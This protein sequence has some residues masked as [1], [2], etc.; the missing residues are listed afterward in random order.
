[1]ENNLEYSKQLIAWR[2]RRVRAMA[3]LEAGMP[4]REI[5]TRLCITRQ[6]LSQLEAAERAKTSTN[7]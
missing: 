3:W 5:A 7:R 1:M 6:R 2:E 4:R